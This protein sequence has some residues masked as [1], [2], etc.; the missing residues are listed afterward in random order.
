MSRPAVQKQ[1]LQQQT[2]TTVVPE[3]KKVKRSCMLKAVNKWTNTEKFFE[4]DELE[5]AKQWIL[6][7][8]IQNKMT[9]SPSYYYVDRV[10][11]D[12]SEPYKMYDLNNDRIIWMNNERAMKKIQE[13][14]KDFEITDHGVQKILEYLETNKLKFQLEK[15][16]DS[17]DSSDSDSSSL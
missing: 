17:D 2:T 6:D 8:C 7:Q 3:P 1:K 12:G 16:A 5:Q 10:S 15:Q 14:V 9:Y 11:T 13:G 4:L